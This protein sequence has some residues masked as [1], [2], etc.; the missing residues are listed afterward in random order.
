MKAPNSL[1]TAEK[2]VHTTLSIK[3]GEELRISE[4][5]L[6]VNVMKLHF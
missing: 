5:D 3:L 6:T 2:K 4:D 1:N